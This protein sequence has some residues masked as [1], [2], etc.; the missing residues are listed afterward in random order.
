MKRAYIVRVHEQ[1]D[2]ATVAMASHKRI[3]QFSN[4][5]VKIYSYERSALGARNGL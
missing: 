3:S 5:N 2:M 1:I 4:P